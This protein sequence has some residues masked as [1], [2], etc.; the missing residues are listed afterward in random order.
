MNRWADAEN[1]AAAA[2]SPRNI[3]RAIDAIVNHGTLFAPF[4][5]RSFR[6]KAEEVIEQKATLQEKPGSKNAAY[7]FSS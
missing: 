2:G 3:A 1:K 7:E 6:L 5:K 4:A